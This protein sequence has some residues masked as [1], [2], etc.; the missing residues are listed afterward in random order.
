M[1]DE[2]I[3]AGDL[4]DIFFLFLYKKY[5]QLISLIWAKLVSKWVSLEIRI[6]GFQFPKAQKLGVCMSVRRDLVERKLNVT[7]YNI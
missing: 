6:K 1:L 7:N 3:K 2:C 4:V 5:L